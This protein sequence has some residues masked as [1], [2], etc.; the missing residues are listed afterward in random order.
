MVIPGVDVVPSSANRPTAVGAP[1]AHVAAQ[2]ILGD[3]VS[4]TLIPTTLSHLGASVTL[5]TPAALI[6]LARLLSTLPPVLALPRLSVLPL[7]PTGLA[8]GT[9]LSSTGQRFH[10]IPEP[11]DMIKRGRLLALSLP[12]LLTGVA[13]AKSLLCLVHLLA[14][15]VETL[16]DTLFRSVGIGID[17]TA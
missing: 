17:S 16:A 2:V 11:F 1:V 6:G 13:R 8:A 12:L 7:L 14:Q 9:V 5:A 10:L 3:L 4:P 15:L